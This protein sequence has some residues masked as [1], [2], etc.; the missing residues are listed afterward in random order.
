MHTCV[1]TKIHT[2]LKQF[3]ETRHVPGL[4]MSSDFESLFSSF[5]TSFTTKLT[6]YLWSSVK[7]IL[8]FRVTGQAA[9]H[10]FFRQLLA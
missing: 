2:L 8:I 5:Y 9:A 7:Y 1:Q 3:Q 4:K 6:E 10:L